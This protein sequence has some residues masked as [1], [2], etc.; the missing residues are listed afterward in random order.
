MIYNI[1][2]LPYSTCILNKIIVK[3]ECSLVRN[4]QPELL[5]A[6]RQLVVHKQSKLT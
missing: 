2:C 1:L 4:A 6:H 3:H 5:R